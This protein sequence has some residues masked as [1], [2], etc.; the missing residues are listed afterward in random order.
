M[1]VE[2]S[3]SLDKGTALFAAVAYIL[4]DL[5]V[6]L[7]RHKWWNCYIINEKNLYKKKEGNIYD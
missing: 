5:S 2:N 7:P 3:D 4:A 1:L 6:D